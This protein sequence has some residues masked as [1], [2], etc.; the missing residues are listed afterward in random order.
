MSNLKKK[1][2]KGKQIGKRSEKKYEMEK[3]VIE[4][5]V[6]WSTI[7]SMSYYQCWSNT[8][9]VTVEIGKY[10]HNY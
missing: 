6:F 4:E 10:R 3:I 5:T 1:E 7:F 8:Q 9:N 2:N